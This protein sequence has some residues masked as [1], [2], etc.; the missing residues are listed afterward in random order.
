MIPFGSAG[1]VQVKLVLG[2]CDLSGDS[3][4]ALRDTG[5]LGA[6]EKNQN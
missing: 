2:P 4:I 6:G 1:I 3:T 5:I